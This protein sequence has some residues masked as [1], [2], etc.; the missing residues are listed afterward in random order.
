LLL[1]HA[2]P[3]SLCQILLPL[4][5]K[6]GLKPLEN[7][8]VNP[9]ITQILLPPIEKNGLKPLEN[10]AVSPRHA[11]AAIRILYYYHL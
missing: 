8:A 2:I 11:P 4:V 5:E 7:I 6:N 3:Q 1:A 9:Y 10:V